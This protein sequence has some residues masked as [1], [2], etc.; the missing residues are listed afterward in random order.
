LLAKNSPPTSFK[1]FSLPSLKKQR[2]S[3]S[4]TD[5]RNSKTYKSNLAA[6]E[7]IYYNKMHHNCISCSQILVEEGGIFFC[8]FWSFILNNWRRTKMKREANDDDDDDD[9][10]G[11]GGERESE[12]EI[13][14]AQI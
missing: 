4:K 14:F 11:G 5:K 6:C 2:K 10:D 13:C 1:C 12:R 9:D 3:N 7:T 8:K